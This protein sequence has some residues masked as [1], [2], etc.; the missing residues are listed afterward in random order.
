MLVGRRV[1]LA[2][3]LCLISLDAQ[4]GEQPAFAVGQVWSIKGSPGSRLVVGRV[5]PYGGQTAIHIGLLWMFADA[6]Q[7]PLVADHLPFDSRALSQSVDTLLFTGVPTP[8]HFEDGYR[9]WREASETQ[10]AG[11][12]TLSIAD[13]V[14]TIGPARGAN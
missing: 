1:A 13:V 12:F 2:S 10:G 14:A 6:T 9:T 11:V 3:I 8:P 7:P 5:E 4:A